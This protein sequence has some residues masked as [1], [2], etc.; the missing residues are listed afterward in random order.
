MKEWKRGGNAAAPRA[1]RPPPKKEGDK[2]DKKD[3]K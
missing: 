1:T 3:E 2:R